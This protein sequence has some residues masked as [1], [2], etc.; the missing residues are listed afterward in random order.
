MTNLYVQLTYE[1]Y[2]VFEQQ[3]RDFAAL[4]TTHE[5]T[6]MDDK[7]YHKSLR[8]DIGSI[9]FEVHGPIVKP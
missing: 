4:E 8:L 3:L 7:F 9:K 5:S 2:K 1:E 6:N